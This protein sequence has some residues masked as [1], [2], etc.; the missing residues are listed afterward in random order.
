M[1]LAIDIG[2]TNIVLGLFKGKQILKKARFSTQ[3]SKR[4]IKK[5]LDNALANKASRI[6]AAA[7]SSVV[8]DVTSALVSIFNKSYKINPVVIGKDIMVPIKNLYKY[9]KQVGQDR[10]VN[11][12][13]C[14][15]KYG[16]PAIIIDFGT[17]TTF[18]FI[19]KRGEYAGGLITP[20]VQATIEGLATRAA[21]LP[22]IR[23]RK[24]KR[25]IGNNTIGSIRSGIVYGL[26]GTC[27]G[28]VRR[29]KNRQK[30]KV[31]TIATGGTAELFKPYCKQI[32]TVDHDM[33]IRGIFNIMSELGKLK[34][35]RL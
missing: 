12:Y 30:G 3:L 16:S 15:K 34:M 11:A 28:I 31:I 19:N 32:D 6:T 9:P 20:G 22:K 7:I 29:I 17:A 25:L 10:L 21:L 24:P 1:F 18:D 8:P 5:C 2:N 27:D 13:A 4:Q 14:L 23:L 33:T 26:A 35:I